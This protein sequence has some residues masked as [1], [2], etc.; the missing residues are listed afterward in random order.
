MVGAGP[1]GRAASAGGIG[2]LRRRVAK[3]LHAMT[4]TM[5]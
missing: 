1:R 4:R 2:Q 3:P 5:L